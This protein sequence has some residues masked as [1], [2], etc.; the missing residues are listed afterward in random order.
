[1]LQKV[2]IEAFV[3]SFCLKNDNTFLVI[4]RKNKL[5]RWSTKIWR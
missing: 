1:M 5:W 2:I 4:S 3:I